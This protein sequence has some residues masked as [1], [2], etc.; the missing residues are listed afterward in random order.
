MRRTRTTTLAALAAAI[1]ALALPSVASAAFPGTDGTVVWAGFNRGGNNNFDIYTR[2]TKGVITNLTKSTY[3]DINPAVSPDGKKIAFASNRDA[4]HDGEI[5][6]MGIDGSNPVQLTHNTVLDQEPTW[7]PDG[8]QIA[9]ESMRDGVSEIYAMNADGSGQ[10]RLTTSTG[11]WL[12]AWSPDGTTIAFTSARAG[13][14]P[15]VYLMTPTGANQHFLGGTVVSN[16]FPSWSPDGSK[17]AAGFSGEVYTIPSAGGSWSQLTNTAGVNT[18][19]AWSPS[20]T[21]MAFQ[22]SQTGNNEIFSLLLASPTTQTNLV[23]DPAGS[24]Q[25][26]D[27]AP[28]WAPGNALVSVTVGDAGCAPATAKVAAGS[29]VQW[30]FT[31]ATAHTAADDSGLGLFDAGSRT[32]PYTAWATMTAAGQYPYHC[33]PSGTLPATISVPAK[34]APATGTA[35]TAFKLTVASANAPAGYVYDVQVKRPGASAFADLKAGLTKKTLSFTPD[36]GAGTYSFQS[37]LRKVAGGAASLYSLP[38]TITVS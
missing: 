25:G 24:G 34:V 5:F 26:D 17:I 15:G 31:S 37:R 33:G 4:E 32:A 36:A 23:N 11:S 3:S 12:P 19:G 27:R 28:D 21:Q 13:N 16:S 6:V 14:P 38:V 7:S 20:G 2:S 30:N 8:K 35:A 9:F 22:S 18:S 10:T 1:A 29:R